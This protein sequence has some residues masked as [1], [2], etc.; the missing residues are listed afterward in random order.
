MLS[1]GEK[2]PS[3]RYMVIATSK[4]RLT[5]GQRRMLISVLEYPSTHSGHYRPRGRFTKVTARRLVERGFLREVGD[6]YEALY[7][8][9]AR[10][11]L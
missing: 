7:D 3:E 1:W 9:R 6:H 8:P 5:K 11:W 4:P 2:S 10:A